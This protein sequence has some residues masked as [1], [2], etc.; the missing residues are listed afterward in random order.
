MADRGRRGGRG[1]GRGGGGGHPDFPRGNQTQP[2]NNRGYNEGRNQPWSQSNRGRGQH[3]GY[4]SGRLSKGADRGGGASRYPDQST[5]H[6]LEGEMGR[7]ALSG[8]GGGRGRGARTEMTLEQKR[9]LVR[10][11]YDLVLTRGEVQSKMGSKGKPIPLISNYFGFKT[12]PDFIVYK[13]W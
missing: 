7:M 2:Q 10:K 3:Q 5:V 1:C 9:E 11:G 13:Y 4:L 6:A 12:K 8:S